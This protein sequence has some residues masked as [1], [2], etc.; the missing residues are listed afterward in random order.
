MSIAL[1]P[2]AW[3]Q[4]AVLDSDGNLEGIFI[5]FVLRTISFAANAKY[6]G[7]NGMDLR[8]AYSGGPTA[9]IEHK[10]IVIS[11]FGRFAVTSKSG[12]SPMEI[13]ASPMFRNMEL[14]KMRDD[15][16]DHT[17]FATIGEESTGAVLYNVN[18]ILVH[19]FFH[20]G[21]TVI[22]TILVVN[23]LL[24]M[25]NQM[26]RVMVQYDPSTYDA[27]ILMII[28][29]S[30]LYL[31]LRYYFHSW[32]PNGVSSARAASKSSSIP[33]STSSTLVSSSKPTT[34]L[35]AP[36]AVDH[37]APTTSPYFSKVYLDVRKRP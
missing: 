17:L 29:F 8:D 26:K 6:M 2:C 11:T 27:V 1:G 10:W 23:R 25:R 21:L 31:C 32:H 15:P 14:G 12:F 35:K 5:T 36:P 18:I 33:A 30:L 37:S 16:D 24:I 7:M 9:L 13:C 4:E 22:Y 28:E 20:V 19:L 34:S 3:L